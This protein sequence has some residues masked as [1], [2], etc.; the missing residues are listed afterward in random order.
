MAPID[1]GFE[2]AL[3]VEALLDDDE[4]LTVDAEEEA[5]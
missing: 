5:A 1:T 3:D 2:E 4:A